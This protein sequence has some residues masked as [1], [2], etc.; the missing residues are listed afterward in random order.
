MRISKSAEQ[1][2]GQIKFIREQASRLR[3]LSARGGA[4]WA[5]HNAHKMDQIAETLTEV[6][7]ELQ[8][9]G[10]NGQRIG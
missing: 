4:K 2:D 3:D 10:M 1:L 7:R 9:T 8:M 5:E 6:R